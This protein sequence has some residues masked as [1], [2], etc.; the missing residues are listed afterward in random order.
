[1]EA[2]GDFDVLFFPDSGRK[3]KSN[4]GDQHSTIPKLRRMENLFCLLSTSTHPRKLL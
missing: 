2:K 4:V 3:V 1:M